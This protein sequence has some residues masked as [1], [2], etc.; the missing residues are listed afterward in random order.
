MHP[1]ERLRYVARAGWGEPAELGAEAAYALGELAEQEPP[2]LLPACRRLLER[3]PTCGTLWWVAAR[4]VCSG[5]PWAEA[6]RCAQLL[7]DDPTDELLEVELHGRRYVRHGGVSDVASAQVVVLRA[8]AL[9]Q[10]GMVLDA[11]DLGLLEAARELE[12]EL[13]VAAGMGRTLP[14]GLW[15]ALCRRARPSCEEVPRRTGTVVVE[16]SG[17]AKVAGPTGV[18]SPARALAACDCPEPPELAAAW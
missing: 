4:L 10:S 11:D 6:L 5:D 14:P 12:A 8:D 16:L 17:V 1:I 3:N 7:E 13:W 2:A 18:L 15:Q 9:G